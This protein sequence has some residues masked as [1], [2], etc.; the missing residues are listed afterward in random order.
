M[1]KTPMLIITA[2][3]VSIIYLVGCSK[4]SSSTTKNCTNPA[5]CIVNTW[6]MQQWYANYDG[7]VVRIYSNGSSGNLNNVIDSLSWVFTSDNKWTQY[8]SKN[9]D[10]A[11]TWTLFSDDS[12]VSLLSAYS[13]TFA[14]RSITPTVLNIDIAFDHNYPSVNAVN[15][16]LG[17][18]LDT[19]K[20]SGYM[21]TWTTTQ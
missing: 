11:G 15:L 4:K 10:D 17:S 6:Y 8:T 12:T 14:I 21:V 13:D 9:V 16:A 19:A 3:I 5:D 7:T 1:K 18:G 2:L 20:L